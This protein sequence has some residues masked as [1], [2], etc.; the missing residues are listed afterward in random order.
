MRVAALQYDVREDHAANLAAV[1][2]RLREARERGVALVLLPEMW[3]GS[4]PR[5]RDR[6][7]EHAARDRAS[8]AR[9]AEL[10]GELGLA[11]AGSALALE[12]ERVLNRLELFEG[13]RSAWSY[14]KVHLFTPTAEHEVFDAGERA[15][16]VHASALGRLTGVV[17]YDLRFPEVLRVPFRRGFDLA[18]VCAQ[19][20]A[21]RIAHWT[22]LCVARAVENQAFVLGCNRTGTAEIGRK[23][24]PLDFPGDS[25][26]VSPYGE[27]L[28]GPSREPGLVVADLDLDQARRFRTRIPIAKDERRDLYRAWLDGDGDAAP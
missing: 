8:C 4:F 26:V 11:L 2:P 28:A 15:P 10:S 6:A 19:W 14:D 22:A 17:C 1:E 3:A 16:G 25:L 20:P 23:R 27:V 13:G 5:G 9:L 24:R 7:A 12:G 18:L 21:P